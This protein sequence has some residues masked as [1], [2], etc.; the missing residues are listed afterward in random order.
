[1]TSA[2]FCGLYAGVDRLLIGSLRAKKRIRDGFFPLESA[3][4]LT[5]EKP[6]CELWLLAMTAPEISSVDAEQGF[7]IP[8]ML[9]MPSM[10]TREGH[11]CF[12]AHSDFKSQ[13]R[14]SSELNLLVT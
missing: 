9:G 2:R 11:A 7:L 8:W 3:N 1:M 14:P 6:G 4:W 5:L 10:H 13:Y 12:Y